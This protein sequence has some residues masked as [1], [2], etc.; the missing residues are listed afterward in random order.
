MTDL[1]WPYSLAT[2]VMGVF[3]VWREMQMSV[4]KNLYQTATFL[5]K[6]YK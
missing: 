3:L 2:Y 4:E 1:E 6:K 5:G